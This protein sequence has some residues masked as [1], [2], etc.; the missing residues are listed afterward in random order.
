[1]PE[2][3]TIERDT[4][5]QLIPP[6][7]FSTATKRL[8]L[9]DLGELRMDAV[10]AIPRGHVAYDVKFLTNFL[11]GPDTAIQQ[12]RQMIVK[13]NTRLK[14]YDLDETLIDVFKEPYT[15]LQQ[16]TG[17]PY[18]DE[19]LRLYEQLSALRSLAF[20]EK[21][22][23]ESCRQ[24]ISWA[25]DTANNLTVEQCQEIHLFVERCLRFLNHLAA[26]NQHVYLN[27]TVTSANNG[28]T[29]TG[30]VITERMM[31]S[32]A[33]AKETI[34][35]RATVM[36]QVIARQIGITGKCDR[37]LKFQEINLFAT[38]DVR[39]DLMRYV[40][41]NQINEYAQRAERFVAQYG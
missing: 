22:T 8:Q 31:V 20:T 37:K 1:M 39:H 36:Q 9:D 41:L 19:M 16:L 28:L 25:W 23:N 11:F 24:Q 38:Y 14:Q 5:N 17:Q 7:R 40:T 29:S 2:P 21:A 3:R 10:Q 6:R 32:L 26:K 30:N 18:D 15:R 27:Y 34:Q 12:L 35:K 13:A 33:I 4:L